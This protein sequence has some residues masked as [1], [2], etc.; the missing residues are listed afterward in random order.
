MELHHT[1]TPKKKKFKGTIS[2]ENH[3]QPV[4]VRKV[5]FL[6]T[7]SWPSYWMDTESEWLAPLSLSHKKGI[8][9]VALPWQCQ[10]TQVWKPLKPSQNLNTQCCHTHSIGPHCTFRFSAV[11]CL[12]RQHERTRWSR[13]GTAECHK[14]MAAKEWDYHQAGMHAVHQ[15]WKATLYRYSDYTDKNYAYC[16]TV[17]PFSGTVQHLTC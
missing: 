13:R 4:E 14:P 17:V 5:L 3:C 16:N 8:R 2:K 9:C 15:R 1:T 11:W 6:W 10:A 12:G 7:Y